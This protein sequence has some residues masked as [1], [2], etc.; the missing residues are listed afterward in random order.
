MRARLAAAAAALGRWSIAHAVIR[1]EEYLFDYVLYPFMLYR[2]GEWLLAAF[3]RLAGVA[4]PPSPAAGYW[5]GF[6]LLTSASIGINLLYIRA[7]DGLRTDWFGFEALKAASERYVSARPGWRPWRAVVRYGAF[8]YLSI[9]HSP[10]FGALFMRGE[11]NAFAMTARDWRIFWVALLIANLGWAGLVSG[12][13][14]L[15][16]ALAP[17]LS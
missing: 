9:W 1:I 3:L 4:A 12:V 14:E 17:H 7:Y 10:L 5:L 2:G 13:A 15:V 8:A 6:C 16:S 11:T